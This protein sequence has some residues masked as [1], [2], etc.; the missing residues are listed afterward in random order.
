MVPPQGR[1]IA[2]QVRLGQSTFLETGEVR[3]RPPGS[4]VSQLGGEIHDNACIGPEDCIIVLHQS[5]AADFITQEQ[6]VGGGDSDVA[7]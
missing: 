5:V 4:F 2:K 1:D 6:Y 7:S 3:E